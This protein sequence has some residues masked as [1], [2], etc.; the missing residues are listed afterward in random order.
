MYYQIFEDGITSPVKRRAPDIDEPSIG[1]IRARDIAPPRS[2]GIIKRAVA[3]AEDLDVSCISGLFLLAGGSGEAADDNL[4]VD[5]LDER[6]RGPGGNPDVPIAIVL[7][8]R[9]EEVASV[10]MSQT[11]P[12]RVAD[13][14]R[15]KGWKL[16]KT[17]GNNVC[18]WPRYS[19]LYCD[20]CQ[21]SP[22]TIDLCLAIKRRDKLRWLDG[23]V[24]SG[25]KVFVDTSNLVNLTDWNKTCSYAWPRAQE[26]LINMFAFG[27]DSMYPVILQDTRDYGCKYR[28]G[29]TLHSTRAECVVSSL[30]LT[31]MPADSIELE[32]DP[33]ISRG[34]SKLSSFK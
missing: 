34:K 3:K 5:I 21:R 28:I 24:E 20:D 29:L 30:L 6:G 15:P 32:P 19:K 1:R 23:T 14:K 25:K 18:E 22:L 26:G 9:A 31:V 16:G 13:N 12:G 11:E 17:C 10:S 33:Q 27:A 2:V 8:S 7:G 4:R